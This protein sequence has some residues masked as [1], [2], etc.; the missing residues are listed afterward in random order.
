MVYLDQKMIADNSALVRTHILRQSVKISIDY[1]MQS[2]TGARRIY[3]VSV[4]GVGLISNYRNQFNDILLKESPYQLIA[5]LKSK[6]EST[7]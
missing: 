4:E 7:T 5:R 6:S 2:K 3:D 1:S